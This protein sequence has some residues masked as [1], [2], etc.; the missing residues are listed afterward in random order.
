MKWT[1]NFLMSMLVILGVILINSKYHTWGYWMLAIPIFYIFDKIGEINEMKSEL[2]WMGNALVDKRQLEEIKQKTS[3]YNFIHQSIYEEKIKKG[4]TIDEI[5]QVI[6]KMIKEN[7]NEETLGFFPYRDYY[8]RMHDLYFNSERP[9]QDFSKNK[10]RKKYK[11]FL[12]SYSYFPP[13]KLIL[14]IERGKL[15]GWKIF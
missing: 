14:K 4:A 2:N 3:F 6:L 15:I 8:C 1:K 9:L 11:V 12:R 13:Q 10:P 7:E 5:G